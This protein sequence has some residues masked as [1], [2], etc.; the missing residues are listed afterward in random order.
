M[1]SPQP[2]KKEADIKVEKEAPVNPINMDLNN[3]IREKERVVQ[4]SN[5]NSNRF[6]SY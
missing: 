2:T 3:K 5:M 1:P 4:P 6:M